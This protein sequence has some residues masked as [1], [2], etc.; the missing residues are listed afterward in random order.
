[1]GNA[2][3]I[4]SSSAEYENIDSGEYS[5][6]DIAVSV[7]RAN[8]QIEKADGDFDVGSV[9]DDAMSDVL[10]TRDENGDNPYER[11]PLPVLPSNEFDEFEDDGFSY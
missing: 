5:S 3:L 1:M 11:R 9:M 7:S 6:G 10:Y 8:E 2:S 4:G